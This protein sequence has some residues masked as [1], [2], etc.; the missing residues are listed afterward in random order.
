LSAEILRAYRLG[1]EELN[2]LQ[3]RELELNEELI[4]EFL[5]ADIVVV[6][7][8]VYNFS[9]PIQ[10][11]AW[12]D[13]ILMAGRTFRYTEAGSVGMAGNKKVVIVSS[14]GSSYADQQREGEDFHEAYLRKVFAFVGIG[15][16]DVVRADG[17]D[18][19]APARRAALATAQESLERV[20]RSCVPIP[21]TRTLL[22][23]VQCT[24]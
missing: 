12:I 23:P 1:T 11:R 14:C 10:L 17:L 13:R 16:I 9:V 19:G 20:V 3:R 24:Q 6:G 15:D 7:A 4:Q 18:M 22:G 8:P 5:E 21:D 2:D